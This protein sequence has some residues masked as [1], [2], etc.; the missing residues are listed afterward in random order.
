MLDARLEVVW[1]E[2]LGHAAEELEGA[3]MGADPVRQLLCPGGL[4]KGVVGGAEHGNK[5]LR[6]TDFARQ[7]R[8]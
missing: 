7:R 5:E 1:H 2:D 8:R 3:D 4:G 6:L